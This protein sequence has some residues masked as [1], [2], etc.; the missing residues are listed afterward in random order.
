MSRRE[1]EQRAL[2]IVAGRY[3]RAQ[4]ARTAKPKLSRLTLLSTGLW[5][6]AIAALGLV[7]LYAYQ[8]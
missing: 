7:A 3:D 1:D 5:I 8:P 4:H 2:D 6:A